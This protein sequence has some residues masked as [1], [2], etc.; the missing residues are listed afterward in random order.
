M[1]YRIIQSKQFKRDVATLKR[2]GLEMSRLTSVVGMLSLGQ[3]LPAQYHDHALRGASLGRR[4][5]H[6][7]PDWLLVYSKSE[8]EITLFLIRTGTHRDVGFEH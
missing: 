5:C 7:A 3:R 8:D 2:R 4:E 6:I 1:N